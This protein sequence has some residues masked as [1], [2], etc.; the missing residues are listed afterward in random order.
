M[1]EEKEDAYLMSNEKDIYDEMDDAWREQEEVS[2]AEAKR[3]A[4]NAYMR[5]RNS[6]R[7]KEFNWMRAHSRVLAQELTDSGLIGKL[8]AASR[9]YLND[10]MELWPREFPPLMK[11]LFDGDVAVGRS[12]TA[13]QCI[14]RIYKGR[15]EMRTLVDRWKKKGWVLRYE[16]DPEGGPLDAMYVI[17]QLNIDKLGGLDV[18]TDSL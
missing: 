5:E 15:A 14:E 10:V 3:K 8:S 17:E 6:R 7:T 13:R 1:E 18:D 12:V 2:I 11:K 4:H 9:K 16:I